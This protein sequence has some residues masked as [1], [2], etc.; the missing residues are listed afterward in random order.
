MTRFLVPQNRFSGC[1]CRSGLW[2]IQDRRRPRA[3]LGGALLRHL[4]IRRGLGEGGADKRAAPH[5]CFSISRTPADI[6]ARQG[7]IPRPPAEPPARTLSLRDDG[8]AAIARAEI[9][10]A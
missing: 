9:R 5:P 4:Q 3:R 2:N 10:A 7:K 8:S 6:N 1:G